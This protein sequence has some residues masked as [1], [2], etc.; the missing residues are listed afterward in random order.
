M[1]LV[2]TFWPLGISFSPA[3]NRPVT[4]YETKKEE[5]PG[6]PSDQRPIEKH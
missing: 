5:T 6:T 2:G 4:G 1:A 3:Q